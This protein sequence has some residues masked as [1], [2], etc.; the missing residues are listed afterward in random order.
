MAIYYDPS[1]VLH[2]RILAFI[3]GVQG[4]ELRLFT[5]TFDTHHVLSPKTTS[6]CHPDDR[7]VAYTNKTHHH[8]NPS[9]HHLTINHRPGSSQP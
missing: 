8:K 9:S 3:L 5:P 6:I 2:L 4:K 1:R 7:A